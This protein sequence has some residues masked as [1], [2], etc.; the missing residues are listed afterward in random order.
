MTF[1]K[2]LETFISEKGLDLEQVF[3]V[4]GKSGPN[5]IPLACVVDAIKSAPSQEQA[6]IKTMIVKI[7]FRNGD[8]CHY[9]KHLAQAIAI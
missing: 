9:F 3:T 7:D 8:V 2:W 6:G 5:Y 1:T 4:N